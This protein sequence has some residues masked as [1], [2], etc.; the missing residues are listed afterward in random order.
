MTSQPGAA[1]QAK[2]IEDTKTFSTEC[3]HSVHS[4][5][6]LR[7]QFAG[8]KSKS[9]AHSSVARVGTGLNHSS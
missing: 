8:Y 1:A 5:H 3:A 6:I 9:T 2:D 4:V 7:T